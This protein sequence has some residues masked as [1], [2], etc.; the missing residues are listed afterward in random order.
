MVTIRLIVN[1]FIPNLLQKGLS[2]YTNDTTDIDVRI[3][4]EAIALPNSRV[5]YYGCSKVGLVLIAKKD[6]NFSLDSGELIS[7]KI[8][9]QIFTDKK[10]GAILL[11]P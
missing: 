7:A 8:P 3:T 10:S 2:A 11:E 6:K 5:G 4:S 9:Q 1:N